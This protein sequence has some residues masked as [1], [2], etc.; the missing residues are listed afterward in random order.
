[1]GKIHRSIYKNSAVRIA[2]YF[3]L[4]CV[5]AMG[6]ITI[7]ASGAKEEDDSSSDVSYSIED[8]AGVWYFNDGSENLTY[9]IDSEGIITD[10]DGDGFQDGSCSITEE[11][12]VTCTSY[13]YSLRLELTQ[14]GTMSSDKY[15]ILGTYTDTE[16]SYILVKYSSNLY[17][18]DWDETDGDYGTFVMA[19]T[20]TETTFTGNYCVI[21]ETNEEG[22]YCYSISGTREENV[23]EGTDS[24]DRT[25]D[26]EIDNENLSGSYYDPDEEVT[27]YLNQET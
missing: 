27:G 4:I 2:H 18:G 3:L 7:V 19:F 17:T 22:S 15:S 23:Y 9:T 21:E 16:L 5:T 12:E 8:L 13:W 26:F 6:L 1:M 25:F 11:G 10:S 14:T 24:M 20:Q